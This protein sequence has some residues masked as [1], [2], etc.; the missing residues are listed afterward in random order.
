MSGSKGT[1]NWIW[2]VGQTECDSSEKK[3]SASCSRA[4]ENFVDLIWNVFRDPW[5]DT[6]SCVTMSSFHIKTADCVRFHTTCRFVDISKWRQVLQAFALHHAG[7]D[8][9]LSGL[10]Q[11][12]RIFFSLE[13]PN[14]KKSLISQ[15][16]AP[17]KTTG[18]LHA[19]HFWTTIS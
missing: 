17:I 1:F 14:A 11:T 12:S 13:T 19:G 15:P 9:N 5:S 6:Y 8:W 4:A 7:A 3:H 18:V 2:E 16:W 10:A